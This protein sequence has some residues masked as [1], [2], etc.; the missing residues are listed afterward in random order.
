[1]R[2]PIASLISP[3]YS[4]AVA[5]NS[6]AGFG[7][8]T[9]SRRTGA[10]NSIAGAF[11]VLVRPCYGSRAWETERSAGFLDSRFANPRTAASLRLATLVA[12]PTNQ[13]ALPMITTRNPSA[14]QARAAAHRAMAMS[15]LGANSS[16]ATRLARYN[17]HMSVARSLQAL[18]A[19]EVTH[20]QR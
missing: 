20:G 11:F 2:G 13:G 5:A 3:V 12:A 10:H 6:A 17:R 7:D 19:S 15:A 8:P 14:I 16:L 18:E 1:M 4:Q 9:I